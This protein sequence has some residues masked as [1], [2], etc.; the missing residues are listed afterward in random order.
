MTLFVLKTVTEE[1]D[2]EAAFM[3]QSERRQQDNQMQWPAA[4]VVLLTF[5]QEQLVNDALQSLLNQDCEDIEIVISDDCSTDGTWQ[6]IQEGLAGYLGPKKIIVIRNPVNIGIVENFANA[7]KKTSGDLIF[8]AAGDDISM[9]NRCS[10]SIQFWLNCNKKYD[11][12]AADA[13]DMSYAG[14]HLRTKESD[15]LEEWTVKK[16]FERRP[17]FFGA[18]FMMTRVLLNLAPLNNQLPYEDQ[19]LV[20]RSL[21]MGGAIRLPVPLVCHR[22]GGMTQSTGF[23]FGHRRS[24]IKIEMAR[25]VHEL[26]QFLNDARLLNQQS[27]IEDLVE[28][29]LDLYRTIRDL[30]EGPTS[31]KAI[32]TFWKSTSV[33]SKLKHRYLRYYLFYP[34]LAIGHSI[35]DTIRII[36]KKDR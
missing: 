8:M 23:K 26:Q 33:P 30:F 17:Y 21:L 36:K 16:W 29:R 24:K 27:A 6:K 12:V 7:I 19:C 15:R 35:R 34:F 5:N 32:K 31:I 2:V 18:S 20:F 3:T 9:P 22:R 10:Q 14:E 25:E 13:I 28:Q 11:L 1:T 4:S